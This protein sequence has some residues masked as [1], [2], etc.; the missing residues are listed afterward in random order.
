MKRA[1]ISEKLIF[2]LIVIIAAVVYSIT[3]YNSHGF[4]HADEQYQIIEFA[5]LKLG[6][7]TPDELAWEFN[8]QIRPSLQPVIGFVVLK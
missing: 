1:I 4:Y 6:T 2:Q 7:H 5:G 8:I 3:A